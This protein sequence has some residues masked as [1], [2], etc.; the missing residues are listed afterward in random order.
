M[1]VD[2]TEFRVYW[3]L[4]EMNQEDQVQVTDELIEFEE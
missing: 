2:I 1:E 3:N 4:D